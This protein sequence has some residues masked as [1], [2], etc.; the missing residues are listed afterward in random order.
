VLSYASARCDSEGRAGRSRSSPPCRETAHW[1]CGS[2][3]ELHLLAPYAGAEQQPAKVV[4]ALRDMKARAPSDRI[5]L[6]ST[7]RQLA[8]YRTWWTTAN[9]FFPRA[10][11][12]SADVEQAIPDAGVEDW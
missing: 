3:A 9:G 11:D 8:Q 7:A 1:A 2:H 5:A 4:E 6:V 12:L 10:A